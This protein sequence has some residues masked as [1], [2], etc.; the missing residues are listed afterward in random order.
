MYRGSRER[1]REVLLKRVSRSVRGRVL[2]QSEPGGL[3][4]LTQ[5]FWKGV[6]KVWNHSRRPALGKG[7][8]NEALAN[9]RGELC[10]PAVNKIFHPFPHLP[11]S[12]I[13]WVFAEIAYW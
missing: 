8:V 4:A 7:R 11:V 2:C 1:G 12:V 6:L 5:A 10:H 13:H 9:Y 3:R